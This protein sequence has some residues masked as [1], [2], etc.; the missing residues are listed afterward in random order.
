M[1]CLRIGIHVT[2]LAEKHSIEP[3]KENNTKLRAMR[4]YTTKKV[5]E[6]RPLTQSVW[7]LS[8]PS[9]TGSL[10]QKSQNTAY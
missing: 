1:A 5:D 7:S 9:K 4:R 10:R 3:S 6:R 8:V 2:S